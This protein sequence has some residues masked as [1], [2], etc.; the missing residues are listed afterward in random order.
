VRDF[1]AREA[2]RTPA[3]WLLSFGHGSALFVVSAVNVHAITHMKEGLGYSIEAAA[4]FIML[5]TVCQIAGI[6]IGWVIGD[7]Y[8]KRMIA[9][10]CMV[11]HMAGLLCLTY[12]TNVTLVVA[13]AVLHGTAWTARAVHAGA[14]RRLLRA[15]RDRHDPRAVFRHHRHRPDRRRHDRRHARRPDGQLPRRL[16]RGGA[17]RRRRIR[18][19]PARQ[20][21]AASGLALRQ[22]RHRR[23]RGNRSEAP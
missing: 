18:V 14:A 22:N 12:A 7:R 1:T 8:D 10:V 9:A 5:Q 3:F 21:A 16:Y 17:A 15:Q 11:L 23:A 13:F 4:L 19:L 20:A 6:A 2:I